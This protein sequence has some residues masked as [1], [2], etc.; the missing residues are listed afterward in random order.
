MCSPHWRTSLCWARP[1]PPARRAASR[2]G[3]ACPPRPLLRR[4]EAS[5]CAEIGTPQAHSCPTRYLGY[6][7]R[8]SPNRRACHPLH[9]VGVSLLV[10]MEVILVS[11]VR[12]EL[13]VAVADLVV[14]MQIQAD[15][16]EVVLTV[17]H[18]VDQV[19][20]LLAGRIMQTL[21]ILVGEILVAMVVRR[22]VAL[23]A[24]LVLL[25]LLD[26]MLQVEQDY[27]LV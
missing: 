1:L 21:L 27:I 24:V 16:V 6:R 14:L 22:E 3:T 15:V 9:V 17:A 19:Q 5:Q 7:Q 13:A 23:V 12:L 26:E 11:T 10:L 25:V 4:A 2:S 20:V 18:L 8:K